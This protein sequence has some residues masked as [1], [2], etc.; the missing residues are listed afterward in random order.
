[1]KTDSDVDATAHSHWIDALPAYL[2]GSLPADRA[3]RVITHVAA[4]AECGFELELERRVAA[5]LDPA[6]EE[7]QFERL[8]KRIAAVAP[9]A[10]P[11]RSASHQW[12]AAMTALAATLLLGTSAAWYR[13]ASSP[14]YTTLADA[15]RHACGSLRVKAVDASSAA[16]DAIA[17]AG[18]RIVAEPGRDGVYTLAAPDPIDA[19]RKLRASSAIRLAEPTDC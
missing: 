5:L 7:A 3:A 17:A 8:W 13:S 14:D 6:H 15:P 18:A 12:L 11:R 2:D 4:C 16:R 1:M 19:L 10:A 9:P